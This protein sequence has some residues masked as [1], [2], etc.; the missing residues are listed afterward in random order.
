MVRRLAISSAFIALATPGFTQD[1]RP[2]SDIVITGLVRTND[3]SARLVIRN[4]GVR[5]G[6]PFSNDAFTKARAA[7]RDKGLYAEVYA[8]T[9]DTLDRKIK[10]IFDIVENPV[11]GN[12]V[13]SGNR[14]I[15]NAK[16]L[17][18]LQTKPGDVLNTKTL[19]EDITKVRRY[20][21]EQGFNIVVTENYQFDPKT[22]TLTVP[23][24]E[25]VIES[26]AITGL[27]KTKD[28][29]VRREL[30]SK[31][32]DPLNFKLLNDD[33]TRLMA[34]NIFQSP[35][36]E[37][38]EVGSEVGKVKVTFTM[39]EQRTAQAGI[40]LGY[41]AQQ[42]L[43]GTLN[44]DE[45]NLQGKGRG[46]NLAWTISGGVAKNSYELGFTEPW[47]DKRN[48]SMS[49]SLYN[50][51]NFRFNRIMTG[52]LTQGL[53]NNQYYEQR[54]GASARLSRPLT[55]DRFTR[56]FISARTEQIQANN[57]QVN[58]NNLT[59]LQIKNLRGALIQNGNVSAMTFGMTSNRVDNPQDPSKGFY[60][61][62]S[63]ELGASGF[64]FQK[65]RLNPDYISA[66]ATP[67]VPRVLVDNRSQQGAFSKLIFDVRK[68]TNL[69]KPRQNLSDTRKVLASRLLVGVA[70]GNISFSEQF[71]MGGPDNLR[72]YFNDRFWGN[73]TFLFSNELRIPFGKDNPLGGVVFADVGDAWNAMDVNR[74]NIP[75][76]T[77]HSQFK[78]QWGLGFG[79]R[80]TIGGIGKI[81][82]DYGF[83]QKG[84][85][86][87]HFSIGQTF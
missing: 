11:I 7:L 59:D 74:E 69:E 52:S 84:T 6:Q 51:L 14:S 50:R 70:T 82:L 86:R 10:V 83:D 28:F 45:Q 41:T 35:R 31:P 17:P 23:L 65:P 81:R 3:E 37:N 60:I 2:V 79:L 62:P 78:P 30:R 75:G 34:L 39:P 38:P 13:F 80:I 12:I 36:F 85:G 72:G 15:P 26:I 53:S 24:L 71:F 18:L 68:Y 77:Q 43:F 54:E 76:F 4:A 27:S 33:L 73:R 22:G 5:E 40:S 57:L 49:A 55:A 19:G 58:Y 64:N 25:T 87:S 63:I 29:V 42:R 67:N 9:E 8:R 47:F 66:T 56:G 21:D 32:G 46:L 1:A 16:L 48:T 61:S 44:F 20:Y